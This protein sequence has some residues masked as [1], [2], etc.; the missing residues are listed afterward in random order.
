M[1]MRHKDQFSEEQVGLRTFKMQRARAVESAIGKIRHG[2]G[3]TWTLLLPEEIELLEWILG[4]TWA[5]TN[6]RTWEGIGFS[7]STPE[8]VDS[9]IGLAQEIVTGKSIG[10]VAIR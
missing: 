8:L 7:F 4:E 9:L 5:M 10:L 3:T 2:L 6:F 1:I